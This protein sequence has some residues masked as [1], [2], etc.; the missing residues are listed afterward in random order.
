MSSTKEFLDKVAEKRKD[1]FKNIMYRGEAIA[2]LDAN[3][4]RA[5][6]SLMGD[7]VNNLKKGIGYE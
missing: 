3:Q 6:I 5:V 7:M 1:S 4:L 2:E